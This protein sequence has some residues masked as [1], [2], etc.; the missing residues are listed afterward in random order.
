MSRIESSNPL[1]RSAR[2]INRAP[3]P[4]NRRATRIDAPGLAVQPPVS[5]A[6]QVTSE[7]LGALGLVGN[8]AS[9]LAGQANRQAAQIREERVEFESLHRGEAATA[10]QTDLAELTDRIASREI[11]LDG[12]TAQ[13]A[14]E[15]IVAE[16]VKGQVGAYADQ[17]R[18]IA[19]PRIAAAFI[20]Q[21][22]GMKNEVN[23]SIAQGVTDASINAATNA[24]ILRARFDAVSL[25]G[26]SE[27]EA[28]TITV[29]PALG[30]A[31][32]AGDRTRFNE[33]REILGDRFAAEQQK[34]ENTLR[35]GEERALRERETRFVESIYET[36]GGPWEA[37][38]LTKRIN[39][40]AAR[41]DIDNRTADQ[42]RNM[43]QS[44]DGERIREQQRA[45]KAASERFATDQAVGELVALAKS[46]QSTGGLAQAPDGLFE[47]TLI[48]GST[49]T[50]PR[51]EVEQAAIGQAF[52]DIDAQVSDPAAATA[53]KTT[54]LAN[55][56]SVYE[57]WQ[58]VM[59]AGRLAADSMNFA[60]AKPGE[61]PAIPK[62][63]VDAYALW[64]NMGSVN[65]TVRDAHVGSQSGREF[66]HAAE[67]AERYIAAGDSQ[68]ALTIAARAKQSEGA[69]STLIASSLVSNRINDKVDSLTSG[70]IF[71]AGVKNSNDVRFT[72]EQL[73]RL[74]LAMG[75]NPDRAVD[76]AAKRVKETHTRVNGFMVNTSGRY[77]PPK[78]DLQLIGSELAKAYAERYTDAGVDAE[79]IALVPYLKDQWTLGYRDSGIPLPN[80]PV[81]DH[82]GMNRALSAI[83]QSQREATIQNIVDRPVG[84]RGILERAFDAARD[85]RAMR[86]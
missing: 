85:A 10:A 47:I 79:D 17:Y 80:A 41:G 13:Q 57:P 52:A 62:N 55:N 12:E 73:S 58:G 49:K 68:Q 33:I 8:A 30:A 50:L 48:D 3:G 23:A 81:F 20:Q 46:A 16:R 71:S 83:R 64:K 86:N 54:L 69:F 7:L 6:S 22:R 5:E 45:L 84:T 25:L 4:S 14:A 56:G 63:L 9:L 59:D 78:E 82:R 35:I 28:T 72:V 11:V 51:D 44:R 21:E 38:T 31:A 43:V 26:I 60:A 66:Y 29:L 70:G 61:T 75:M 24:D 18:K 19:V 40:G 74:Y 76:E 1:V 77:T 34:A 53:A 36:L 2:E 27:D 15:R 32:A 42:L 37:E 39:D 67:L 65:P